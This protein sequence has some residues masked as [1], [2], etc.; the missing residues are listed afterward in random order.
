VKHRQIPEA[1]AEGI[2]FALCR[3]QFETGLCSAKHSFKDG[4]DMILISGSANSGPLLR[5]RTLPC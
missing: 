5:K 2:S 4:G 1:K 3:K